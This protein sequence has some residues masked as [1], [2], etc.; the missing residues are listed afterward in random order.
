MYA[1]MG[2]DAD[3]PA[4]DGL[5]YSHRSAQIVG[6]KRAAQTIRRSVHIA[7]HLGLVIKWHDANHWPKDFFAPA[8]LAL[9]HIQE[10]RGFEIIAFSIWPPSTKNK[11]ASPTTS[12]GKVF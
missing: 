3:H 6:P 11:P 4:F 9:P 10:N 12:I 7:Y 5:G 1:G 8:S 2:V